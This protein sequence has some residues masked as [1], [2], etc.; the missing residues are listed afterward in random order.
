M[1]HFENID[2]YVE[3]ANGLLSSSRVRK[4]LSDCSQALVAKLVDDDVRAHWF[5]GA[6]MALT[7]T[8]LSAADFFIESSDGRSWDD[9]SVYATEGA[10]RKV[11]A[12]VRENSAFMAWTGGIPVQIAF[13]VMDL[14]TLVLFLENAALGPVLEKLSG[15]LGINEVKLMLGALSNIARLEKA[16][17]LGVPFYRMKGFIRPA[18]AEM[19]SSYAF[20]LP[21]APD[22]LAYDSAWIGHAALLKIAD[23]FPFGD[24]WCEEAQ[25]M[26]SLM[27]DLTA[28]MREA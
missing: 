16:C 19:D 24:E 26:S 14:E 3:K 28:R 2:A 12:A 13:G 4:D 27:V 22:G 21:T 23:N 11:Q 9:R 18:R 25:K 17:R 6:Q 7:Y 15:L 20:I 5:Y 8:R 1:I 10:W